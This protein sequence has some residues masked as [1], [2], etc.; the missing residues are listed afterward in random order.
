MCAQTR[1]RFILSNERGFSR[2]GVRTHVNA[3]GKIPSTRGSEDG[4]TRNSASHRTASLTHYP[5]S[6]SGP[7]FYCLSRSVPEIHF[8]YSWGIKRQTNNSLSGVLIIKCITLR[9]Y[10]KHEVYQSALTIHRACVC[11]WMLGMSNSTHIYCI[12]PN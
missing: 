4:E 12:R 3:K 9:M 6:H 5:P 7:T 1:P 11:P 10:G 2:N 8:A